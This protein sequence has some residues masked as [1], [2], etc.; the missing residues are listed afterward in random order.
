MG[1]KERDGFTD[2]H[3]FYLSPPAVFEGFS[4]QHEYTLCCLF[5]LVMYISPLLG[6][7]YMLSNSK[8]V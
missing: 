8:Y 7:I 4:Y 2:S 6:L 1:T 5:L 3:M